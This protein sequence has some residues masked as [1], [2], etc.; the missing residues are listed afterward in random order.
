MSILCSQRNDVTGNRFEW[1]LGVKNVK[2]PLPSYF[3]I[4]AR[5]VK[6]YGMSR[7]LSFTQYDMQVK[8]VVIV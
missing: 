6:I 8:R 1:Q 5:S 2:T 4:L 7:L 3:I